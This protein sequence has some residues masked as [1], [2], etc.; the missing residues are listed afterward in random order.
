VACAGESQPKTNPLRISFSA[1]PTTL[2]PQKAGDFVS[3]TL[4]SM[5]YEGLTRCLPGGS[6]ELAMAEKVEISDDQKTYIFHLRKA[7]WS[8]GSPV[9]AYDF[10]RSWKN[11]LQPTSL[12]VYLFYP[13]KNV[14]KYIK[15]EA[16]LDTVGIKALD[17]TRFCVELE[18]PTSYFYALTAFP[19]FLPMHLDPNL[20][21]GPFC[22]NKKTAPSEI[23]L[24]KNKNFWNQKEIA[25]EE[26]HIRIVPDETTALHLF[27]RGELDFV[28]GNLSSLPFDALGELKEQ[29]FL[30]PSATTTF[31]SFNTQSPPFSNIHLRKAF[32]YAID[33]KTIV[34][35][36][37][38]SSQIPATSLLPPCFS[39][40]CQELSNPAK[41]RLHFKKGL[42][43]LNITESD[44]EALIL[45]YKPGSMEKRL[46]QT[47]QK[48]WKSV[49]GVEIQLVQ[50]DF[51][52]HAHLLK[53]RNYQLALASWTA[54]FDDPVSIL[55]RFKDKGHLKN[56][57]G[58]EDPQYI[59]LLNAANDSEEREKLLEEAALFL[60]DAAPLTPIY[61]W[62]SPVLL[63]SRITKTGTTPCGGILFERFHLSQ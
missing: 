32:S 23:I 50:L 35:S 48:Q 24:V 53:N 17:E 57:P 7:N 13:I 62:N 6:P 11:I 3:S 46:A 5:L 52:S 33:R 51:K 60:M 18:R 42:N 45:Y 41:A 22:I 36:L 29:L 63:S 19:S 44:L 38:Q 59:Q 43:E 26:I 54:Q 2:D 15:K 55:D 31:C 61:H 27:E 34:N 21:N 39:S 37:T 16:S 58:W 9:T 56:Y 40:D 1:K 4:I 20:F 25:I 12:C 10:E 28:G 30:I 14:E 47:L 8:D 49:L